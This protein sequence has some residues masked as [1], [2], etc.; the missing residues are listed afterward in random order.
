MTETVPQEVEHKEREKV[1]EV[2]AH[3]WY[4]QLHLS[5]DS[6]ESSSV[7]SHTSFYGSL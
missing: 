1:G 5:Q 4:A 2:G 3:D 6:Q 7:D